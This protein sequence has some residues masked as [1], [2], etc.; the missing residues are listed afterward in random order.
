[1]HTSGLRQYVMGVFELLSMGNPDSTFS[2]VINVLL[3]IYFARN[4]F[5]GKTF[6][7]LIF[8]SSPP[9]THTRTPRKTIRDET[10]QTP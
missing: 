7:S 6:F 2:I 4:Q 9:P 5:R 1:M 3:H 8:I 10:N